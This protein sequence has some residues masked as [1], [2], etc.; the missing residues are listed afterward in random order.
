LRS[1]EGASGRRK[2]QGEFSEDV[3]MRAMLAHLQGNCRQVLNIPSPGHDLQCGETKR[4]LKRMFRRSSKVA[5][6]RRWAR[7]RWDSL[8]S[9]FLR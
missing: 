9:L 7:G 2:V 6:F 3:V 1:F 8:R 4:Y 5:A